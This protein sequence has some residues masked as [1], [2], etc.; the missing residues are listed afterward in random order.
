MQCFQNA[1]F[2]KRGLCTLRR[3]NGWFLK[4]LSISREGTVTEVWD[5][6]PAQ[7]ATEAL[8]KQLE[9]YK[10]NDKEDD[11]NKSLS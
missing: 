7:K 11:K 4:S 6:E 9:D 1:V 5:H 10:K 2:P 3:G 8:D